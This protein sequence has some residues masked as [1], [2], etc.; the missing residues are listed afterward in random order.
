M[1]RDNNN[2]QSPSSVRPPIHTAAP[3]TWARSASATSQR[4]RCG[5]SAW[6][7]SVGA[8]RTSTPIAAAAQRS[9]GIAIAAT[10]AATPD[11]CDDRR[12]L[13]HPAESRR[14]GGWLVRDEAE[15]PGGDEDK[16]GRNHPARTSEPHSGQR[17]ST[18]DEHAGE[19]EQAEEDRLD[20]RPVLRGE[21][22]HGPGR[23][24]A[25]GECEHT[26]DQVA[27]VRDNTPADAVGAVR[28]A[29]TKRQDDRARRR[30]PDVAGEDR[31]AARVD[32]LARPDRPDLVVEE[33]RDRRRRGREHGAVRRFRDD[34]PRV[35]GRRRGHGERGEDDGEATEPAAERAR[36]DP[37]R[38]GR[39]R[40]CGRTRR[41]GRS[42][43]RPPPRAGPSQC[44]IAYPSAQSSSWKSTPSSSWAG[45]TQ[46]CSMQSVSADSSSAT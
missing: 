10:A 25:D 19:E 42:H 20:G 44:E 3:A 9:L 5:S 43:P 4:R 41:R 8:A 12:G 40:G 18:R 6:P 2:N 35:R 1:K 37:A 7:A 29:G 34:E 32:D 46:S 24:R 17:G 23:A 36:G 27:V 45:C 11:E 14:I 33:E 21:N 15:A 22:R 30:L 38:W 16:P 26:R 28:E 39:T 31:A 13:R